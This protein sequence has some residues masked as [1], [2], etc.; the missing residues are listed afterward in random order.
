MKN[1][2]MIKD[3]TFLYNTKMYKKVSV[4]VTEFE[5]NI[6]KI[7]SEL[8]NKNI[9]VSVYTNEFDL[10][11]FRLFFPNNISRIGYS[12]DSIAFTN[13]V[14]PE[15]FYRHM[16]TIVTSQYPL[17]TVGGSSLTQPDSIDLTP[18]S[19]LS[20]FTPLAS[21][22]SPPEY[23]VNDGIF[24]KIVHVGNYSVF[25]LDA[26][27]LKIDTKTDAKVDEPNIITECSYVCTLFPPK[28]GVDM[29]KLKI[30][31]VGVYSVTSYKSNRQIVE[32]IRKKVGS[33]ITI[34]DSTACVGGD[35]I[36]F[37]LNF[38][39]VISIEKDYINYNALVNNVN[40]YKLN[41]V[42]ISN[43]NF[44]EDGMNIIGKFKPDV[45]YFDPPWGG[46]DYHIHKNI[47]LYLDNKNIK[48]IIKDILG[49]FK[50]VKMVVL[51]VPLNYNHENL[52]LI[53]NATIHNLK[54]FQ[55]ILVNRSE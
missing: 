33:D 48:D 27:N 20:H 38:K 50:F 45:V 40:I 12:P 43:K 52:S 32:M 2:L 17:T 25:Y 34:M 46:K 24:S 6:E 15:I 49:T 11:M 37:A 3:N 29:N 13:K 14:D 18:I 42:T 51:K 36:G 31:T 54:K 35:T 19:S 28:L 8:V 23:S 16:I 21:F 47:D 10:S 30:T 1:D 9:S 5:E 26:K 4:Q 53:G 55:V 39:H 7:L 22:P 44:V 41:N